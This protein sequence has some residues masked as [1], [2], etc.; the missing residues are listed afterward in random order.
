MNRRQRRQGF[1]DNTLRTATRGGGV[2]SLH[3]KLQ[4]SYF[5]KGDGTVGFFATQQYTEDDAKIVRLKHHELT[6]SKEEAGVSSHDNEEAGQVINEMQ[7]PEEDSG[8]S[9]EESRS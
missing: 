5:P 8:P 4:K 2:L 9:E 7:R 3:K 6:T 1:K